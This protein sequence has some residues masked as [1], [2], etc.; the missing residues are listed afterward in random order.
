MENKDVLIAVSLCERVLAMLKE[1]T[2][3]TV[4]KTA[5]NSIKKNLETILVKIIPYT[6]DVMIT[7][8]IMEML[9]LIKIIEQDS[10]FVETDNETKQALVWK[11]KLALSQ[12]YLFAG[13]FYIDHEFPYSMGIAD[14]LKRIID[15]CLASGFYF[16]YDEILR[17]EGSI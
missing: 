11:T 3:E 5:V 8:P 16:G 15:A 7:T 1:N 17:K 12:L 13:K 14:M 2:R 9:E 6:K 4:K 10:S